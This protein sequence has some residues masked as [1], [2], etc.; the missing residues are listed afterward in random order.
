[1][2]PLSFFFM[3]FSYVITIGWGLFCLYLLSGFLK[4]D[5]LKSDFAPT[6]WGMV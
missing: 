5:F 1:M 4:Q 3:I 6:Q 2:R